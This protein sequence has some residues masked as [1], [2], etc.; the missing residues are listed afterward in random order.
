MTITL[1]VIVI[2]DNEND[3][4]DDNFVAYSRDLTC[5]LSEKAG[6]AAMALSQSFIDGEKLLRTLRRGKQ[7]D[8]FGDKIGHALQ[9]IT[10]ML[11]DLG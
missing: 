10:T 3:N 6:P 4:D 7:R 11:D 2:D 8:V 9:L 1:L 5:R